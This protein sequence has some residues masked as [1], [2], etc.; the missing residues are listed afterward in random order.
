M[1]QR[2]LPT[3][4][5]EKLEIFRAAFSANID[6]GRMFEVNTLP[7][8]TGGFPRQYRHRST[9]PLFVEVSNSLTGLIFLGLD[10]KRSF[11]TE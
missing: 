1:F 9:L 4:C 6:S 8:L 2:L 5:V 3:H 11:S 10:Q 7:T